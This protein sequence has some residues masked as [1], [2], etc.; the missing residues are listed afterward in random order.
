MFKQ[1]PGLIQNHIYS[2][3]YLV[4]TFIL[5]PTKNNGPTRNKPPPTFP[6]SPTINISLAKYLTNIPCIS[7]FKKSFAV[8]QKSFSEN[9]EKRW[10]RRGGKDALALL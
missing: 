6:P 5:S 9:G 8:F 3:Q 10:K 4:T 7:V 2:H 1:L